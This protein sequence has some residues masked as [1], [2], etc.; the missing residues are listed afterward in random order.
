MLTQVLF[1]EINCPGSRHR[2]H[3][4]DTTSWTE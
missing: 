2:G 4:M 3:K 1:V